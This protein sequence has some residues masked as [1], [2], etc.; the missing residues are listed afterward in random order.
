MI[1]Q[2]TTL[3]DPPRKRDQVCG[4]INVNIND[5]LMPIYMKFVPD[6]QAYHEVGITIEGSY[7]IFRQIL[8]TRPIYGI[9]Q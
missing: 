4:L 3:Q 7:K 2:A 1:P 9:L 5:K 8:I 6:D